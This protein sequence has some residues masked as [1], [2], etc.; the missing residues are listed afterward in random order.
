M[1]KKGDL[2][3]LDPPCEEYIKHGGY[4]DDLE[5]DCFEHETG[6][7]HTVNDSNMSYSAVEYPAVYLNHRCDQWVVGGPEQIKE[8]IS[9]LQAALNTFTNRRK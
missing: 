4:P 7:E 5:S 2:V 3:I 1:Y 6:H 8:L 9:D